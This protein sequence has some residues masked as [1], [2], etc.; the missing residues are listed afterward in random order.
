MKVIKVKRCADCPYLEV[1]EYFKTKHFTC[2]H[3]NNNEEC[4]DNIYKINEFCKL[5]EQG[6]E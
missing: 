1:R 5:E 2:N 3:F 6:T 4:I